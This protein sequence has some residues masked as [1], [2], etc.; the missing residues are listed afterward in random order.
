MGVVSLDAFLAPQER[1]VEFLRVQRALQENTFVL[2]LTLKIM[3]V[4]D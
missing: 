1:R 3:E 4:A 2:L